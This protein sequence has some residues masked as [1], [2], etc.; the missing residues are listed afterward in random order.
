MYSGM[1]SHPRRVEHERWS[2]PLLRIVTILTVIHLWMRNM[3]HVCIIN[4]YYILFFIGT[5]VLQSER[6]NISKTNDINIE[7][8][9]YKTYVYT[10]DSW[11]YMCIHNIICL[12]TFVYTLHY[13]QHLYITY[14]Y[15]YNI[16]AFNEHSLRISMCKSCSTKTLIIPTTGTQC[17][18]S[19]KA[20]R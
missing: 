6:T 9:L 18:L 19:I 5:I 20:W 15:K 17:V 7:V 12:H 14:V 16:G 11:A 10:T 8:Y 13:T 1:F 2:D 4:T 3:K